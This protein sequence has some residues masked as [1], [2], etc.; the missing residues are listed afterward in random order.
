MRFDL[1]EDPM[2]R[3][4]N[5]R[6]TDVK[7][8][9]DNS[10]ALARHSDIL[11]TPLLDGGKPV[12]NYRARLLQSN[13]SE[14]AELKSVGSEIDEETDIKY[15]RSL[16]PVEWKDQD[17]YAVM[18]L[19][20]M[21]FRATEEDIKRAYRF[22]VLRHHPDKRQAAGE[23]V[24]PDSDYFACIVKANE[25][26]GNPVKKRSYDSVDPKF[27]DYL[28]PKNCASENEFFKVYGD[29]F[30]LNSRWSVIQPVPLLGNLKT[31]REKV[32]EFYSF[33][34]DF[35]SWREYSYL[36]EEDKEKGQYREERRWIEKQ[37]K[38]ARAK[39]KKEEM[40]RIRNVVDNSYAVDPRISMFKE[41]DVQKKLE[42][43]LARQNAVKL[44]QMEEQ[45]IRE[46][47]EA[48]AREEREK[49]EA[50]ER[51]KELASKKEKEAHK[52][53]MKKERKN[54]RT[55][56]KTNQYY[57][58]GDDEV[59]TN[60]TSVEQLCEILPL[61]EL[62]D[63]CKRLSSLDFEESRD[64]FL[65]KVNVVLKK[66]QHETNETIKV[67]QNRNGHG[68]SN[69][70]EIEWSHDELALLTK[71]V[72]LFPAGTTHRWEVV[73]NFLYQHANAK[74]KKQRSAKEVLA[75]AKDL[76]SADFSKNAL[77][78]EANLK[79]FDLFEKSVKN[80]VAVE[81]EATQ[82]VNESLQNKMKSG[83]SVED[84][85][86]NSSDKL[87]STETVENRGWTSEDQKLLEQALKTYP[88]SLADRW[89]R[90]A[91]C[92]PNR[93]KKECMA[94]F[95]EIAALVKAK[96]SAQNPLK[97]P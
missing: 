77:K 13:I 48:K 94:R 88:A 96:K 39:L 7:D 73:A 33:W 84:T 45:K 59:V 9:V 35:D 17:H 86:V 60:M 53:A 32:E 25:I 20:H 67:S 56:C 2:A 18:G 81:S 95:K 57:A 6:A 76:K 5:N 42:K 28:P 91:D 72:N 97:K 85:S 50:D 71:A 78:E 15:L 74:N 3:S 65:D 27:D 52:R 11:F 54:L 34:Y 90:I 16:D 49:I 31:P 58:V 89:D 93:T 10:L 61:N 70:Q 4:N 79:A 26:L 41:E 12:L 46:E 69:N 36:D 83:I 8:T 87:K 30:E 44:K 55:I 92:V 1:V 37:N 62:E 40:S 23:A 68:N 66:I 22:R 29:W 38:Q 63:L 21:R 24:I 80:A 19:Q 64:V 75:K 51:E 47:A 43:K 82:R 14:W